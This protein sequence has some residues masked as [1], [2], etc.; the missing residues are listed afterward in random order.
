MSKIIKTVRFDK[1]VADLLL[2]EGTKIGLDFSSYLRTIV[3]NHI[4]NIKKTKKI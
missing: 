1:Q 3:Y 4:N 2:K